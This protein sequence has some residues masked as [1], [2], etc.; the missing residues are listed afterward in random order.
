MKKIFFL[1][2]FLLFVSDVH[3]S[4]IYIS[5][6]DIDTGEFVNDCDFLLVDFNNNVIDRWIQ[7]DSYHLISV[8]NGFYK[9]ITRPY[10]MGVFDDNMS[11][12]YILDVYENVEF[13]IYNKTIG[14]PNN[15]N[16]SFNIILP[17][18]FIIVGFIILY[19]FF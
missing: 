8:E 13:N 6:K 4:D 16:Y 10:I 15:L 7:D 3:A 12:S 17:I 18:F 19:K 14:T 1:F 2:C 9:L 5:K 11:E